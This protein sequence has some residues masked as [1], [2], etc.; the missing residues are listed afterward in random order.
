MPVVPVTVSKLLGRLQGVEQRGP[1]DWVA[2]SP[3]RCERNPSLHI[4]VVGDKILLHDFG[5]GS[6]EDILAEIG[7]TW[8]DL[9]RNDSVVKASPWPAVSVDVCVANL[10]GFAT[11][12]RL[13][14][15]V[16]ERT[17]GVRAE[18][19]RGRPALTY[20]TPIGVHRVKYL[21]DKRPKYKWAESGGCGHLYGLQTALSM[22]RV[23]PANVLYLVNGEPA[24][25]AAQLRNVPAICLCAGE[26]AAS[27]AA[28]LANEVWVL[29]NRLKLSRFVL[30]HPQGCARRRTDEAARCGIADHPEN[31]IRRRGRVHADHR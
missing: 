26:G 17:W 8:A 7:L 13:D 24:V 22:L 3:T 9:S 5:G 11:A 10:V 21:D 28:K 6:I 16:L 14:P 15:I 2:L 23:P 4:T 25:W 19:H 30:H 18:T 20:P 31:P 12:R 1:N 27:V 29:P